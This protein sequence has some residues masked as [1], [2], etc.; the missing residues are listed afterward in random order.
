MMES[1]LKDITKKSG[2]VFT[3]RMIGAFFALA[4]NMAAARFMGAEIYGMVLYVFNIIILLSVITKLGLS[5]GLVQFIS[6]LTDDG[7]RKKRNSIVS[8]SILVVS[9]I[10][11]LLAIVLMIFSEKLAGGLLNNAGLTGIIKLMAPLLIIFSLIELTP[12]IFRGI[13][14]IRYRV[15]GKDILLP[16]FKL[17]IVIILGYYGYKVTGLVVSYYISFIIA[18]IYMYYKIVKLDL[19]GRVEKK[20][21][22]DYRN[23]LAFSLPLMMSGLLTFFINKTDIFMIGYFIDSTSVGIYNIALR[24][25]TLTSFVLVAFNTIFAPT[26]ASLYHRQEIEK[27]KKLY[28]VI[29]R[30]ILGLNLIAFSLIL[31]L[32]RDI[33]RVFGT[34]FVYGSL[35]LVLVA[36][37]Q[38]VN[39]GVGTAGSVNIMTGFPRS[40]MYISIITFTLN[41]VLNYYLI[42]LYGIE[43][44]AFASLIS[45]AVMNFIRLYF[46]YARHRFLPYNREYIAVLIS[47]VI[48][49]IISYFCKSFLDINYLLRIVVLSLLY[50]SIFVVIYIKMGISEEDR[51]IFDSIIKKIK[52]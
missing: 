50:I 24:A 14:I 42:P 15:I 32:N 36:I 41:I 52:R 28:Q 7:Q 13:K 21:Y 45:V 2:I 43:G 31:L 3:G 48:S 18:C 46:L 27:M 44:A 47:A 49:F 1:E 4:F 26:I 20:Y 22:A 12:G 16:L 10:S 51:M 6:R 29:T 9:I 35:A 33:M 5:Q 30:W 39:A 34:E 37:G 23:L 38:V 11:L 17:I 40:E 8:F 25:G 19:I